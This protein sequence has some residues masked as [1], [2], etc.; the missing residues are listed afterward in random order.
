MPTAQFT[1]DYIDQNIL[2]TALILPK[3]NDSFYNPSLAE[4]SGFGYDGQLYSSGSIVTP[5]SITSVAINAGV[6]TF[7]ALNSLQVGQYVSI[8]GVSVAG[9]NIV[10]QVVAPTTASEFSIATN[11]ANLSST[12]TSGVASQVASWYAEF[13]EGG[14]NY[15]DDRGVF[16]QAGLILLSPVSLVILDETT[17]ALNLWMQFL[18]SDNYMFGNNFN[19]SNQGWTPSA[20]NYA[21]GVISVTYLPDPGNQPPHNPAVPTDPAQSHMVLSIDFTQDGAYLDVAL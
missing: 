14:D 19:G 11:L 18:L 2:A 17:G 8:L 13:Q 3:N 1:Y 4:H 9:L 10:A 6:A 7:Q 12:S 20:V 5:A 21:D 15:R 16:P